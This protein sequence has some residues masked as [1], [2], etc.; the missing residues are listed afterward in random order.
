MNNSRGQTL[1][2]IP[3]VPVPVTPLPEVVELPNPLGW[4]MWDVAV[5]QSDEVQ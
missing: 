1:P 5:R 4:A 3:F 2:T